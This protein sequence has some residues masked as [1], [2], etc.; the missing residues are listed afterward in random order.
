MYFVL[1]S[2]I[3]K[4][5][6]YWLMIRSETTL[7]QRAWDEAKSRSSFSTLHS[8]WTG[9]IYKDIDGCIQHVRWD[10]IIKKINVPVFCQVVSLQRFA[11]TN[12][13]VCSVSKLNTSVRFSM[14]SSKWTN[15]LFTPTQRWAVSSVCCWFKLLHSVQYKTI[16]KHF[17]W[18]MAQQPKLSRHDCFSL[19]FGNNMLTIV[20]Q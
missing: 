18:W 20:I 13:R 2:H 15:S 17:L 19:W 7:K 11:I 4:D 8:C 9:D 1:F 6:E 5:L 14:Y 12:Y 16:Q 10:R 3:K